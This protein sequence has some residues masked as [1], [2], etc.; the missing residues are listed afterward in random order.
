MH[1]SIQGNFLTHN[2]WSFAKR[3]RYQIA[4]KH[5]EHLRLARKH[6]QKL[7]GTSRIPF[8]SLNQIFRYKNRKLVEMSS[9]LSRELQLE[10]EFE[11]LPGLLQQGGRLISSHLQSVLARPEVL[12]GV[13]ERLSQYVT[14]EPSRSFLANDNNS[15]PTVTMIREAGL[16]GSEHRVVTP[17][18]YILTV[19][20]LHRPLT[21]AGPVVFL[22]H[23]LFSSSADWVIGDRSKAFGKYQKYIGLLLTPL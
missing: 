10:E 21:L 23:G 20:R 16:E 8:P 14:G 2:I 6:L 3:L 22:Q 9:R 19:H 15:K 17:D 11:E 7:A 1:Q 18:G 13:A 12:Q 5:K 4:D